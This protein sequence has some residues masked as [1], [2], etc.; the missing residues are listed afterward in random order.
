MTEGFALHE[1]IFNEDG[2]P[3]DYRFID[4][5]PAFEE[6][7]GLKKDDVVGKLK[8]EV[9]PE[10]QLIGLIFTVKLHLQM[11]QYTLMNI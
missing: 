9:I 7:I 1:I 5:N 6:I 2:K 11:N 10:D 8:S 4:I 3:V